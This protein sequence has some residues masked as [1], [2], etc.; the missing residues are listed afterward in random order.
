[1]WSWYNLAVTFQ[2]ST[3][4]WN[5]FPVGTSLRVNNKGAPS[6]SY[7]Y[8]LVGP[9]NTALTR[10]SGWNKVWHSCSRVRKPLLSSVHLLVPPVCWNVTSG[11]NKT[12]WHWHGGPTTSASSSSLL[13]RRWW[14]L[15]PVDLIS[16]HPFTSQETQ[17]YMTDH[18]RFLVSSMF[19]SRCY[20]CEDQRPPPLTPVNE[21]ALVKVSCRLPTACIIQ[22][23]KGHRNPAVDMCVQAK[24][25]P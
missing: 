15:F 17:L 14:D 7:L 19:T 4:M 25:W 2:N 1:M 9:L 12:G 18:Q 22:E 16:S 8:N 11:V 23:V 13:L 20:C 24:A 5:L 6:Q 3:N 21:G 10:G